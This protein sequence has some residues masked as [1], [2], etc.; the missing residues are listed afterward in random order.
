LIGFFH[1]AD[2]LRISHAQASGIP[3]NFLGAAIEGPSR[4]GFL[5]YPLYGVH[6]EAQGAYAAG[7]RIHPDGVSHAWTLE[8]SQEGSGTLTVTLDG[9]AATL[10]MSPEHRKTGARFDR[11]G[12]ITTHVDGNGQQVYFDDLTY[13]VAG[14][15]AAIPETPPAAPR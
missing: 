4:E 3:E 2:S 5:F 13:L 14:R 1:S 12:V 6:R 11:F 10:P 15:E 7:P 9:Q 8:Y